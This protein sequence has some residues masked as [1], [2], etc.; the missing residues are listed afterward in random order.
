MQ[1][2]KIG[3]RVALFWIAW[4]F[5]TEKA[6]NFRMT[7]QIFQKA[8]RRMAEPKDLLNKRYQ[9]FQRRLARHFLN[10]PDD[11][12]NS[13]S[14]ADRQQ[15]SVPTRQVLGR[16]NAAQSE[17]STSRANPSANN[18]NSQRGLTVTAA[19]VVPKAAALP[20]SKAMNFTIYSE[21]QQDPSSAAQKD[22]L[23]ENSSWT[24]LGSE[25]ER[26]KENEGE[27][28]PFITLFHS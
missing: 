6:E 2:N 26:R 25:K 7:D 23:S 20:L 17:S 3:E 14:V 1:S 22:L 18:H 28:L 24:T 12:V 19:N 9:Q 15:S 27:V 11:E 10:K 5:I 4:A 8:I 16:L 21:P 13:S